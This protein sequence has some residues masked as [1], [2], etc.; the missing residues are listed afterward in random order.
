MSWQPFSVSYA[1]RARREL[2]RLERRL[3]GRIMDAVDNYAATGDGD[4]KKLQGSAEH[5]YRLRVGDWRVIFTLDQRVRIMSVER[6]APRGG[7]YK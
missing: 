3:A 6:V 5:E 2:A 4:V 1:D 7:A